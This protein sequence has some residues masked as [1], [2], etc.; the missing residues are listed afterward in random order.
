MAST[1]VRTKGVVLLLFILC[2]M[3]L[4]LFVWRDVLG[5]V[6]CVFSSVSNR[7]SVKRQLVALVILSRRCLVTVSVLCLFLAVG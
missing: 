7:L 6:L 2:L 4:A 5:A 1:A 3:L